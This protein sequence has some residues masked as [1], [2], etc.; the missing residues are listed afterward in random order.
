MYIFSSI[1]LMISSN[2]MFFSLSARAILCQYSIWLCKCL[3]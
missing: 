2:L 3:I 1:F